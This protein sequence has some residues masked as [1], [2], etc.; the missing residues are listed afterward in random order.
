M[1]QSQGQCKSNF[2]SIFNVFSENHTPMNSIQQID[3]THQSMILQAQSSDPT[4]LPTTTA[5][6]N[7][8][9]CKLVGNKPVLFFRPSNN[10]TPIQMTGDSISIVPGSTGL[11]PPAVDQYTFL[12]GP[13]TIYQG[14]IPN[15]TN[16]MVKVLSP[17]TTLVYAQATAYNGNSSGIKQVA[18][19][20]SGSSFTIKFSNVA[21]TQILYYFAVGV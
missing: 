18:T 13:F 19:V 4:K 10:Q 5:D 7:S 12:P 8:F 6:Q 17:T 16:G 2:Q 1:L 3:G 21:P 15:A 11:N 20:I 9:Y 14:Y